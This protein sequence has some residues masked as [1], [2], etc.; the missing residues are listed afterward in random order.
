MDELIEMPM[1][2]LGS[3]LF[4]AMPLSLR[5]FEPRYMAMLDALL[6][7][8]CPEFGVVLIERGQEV[9]GG[10]QRFSHG[11]VA[12]IIEVASDEGH[13]NVLV[14]GRDRIEIVEWLEDSP[15]P[16]AVVRVL[17]LLLWEEVCEPRR[18]QTELLVRRTLQRASRLDEHLWPSTIDLDDNPVNHIWQLAGIAPIGP[19]DQVRLLGA[20]S[21]RDLL[22]SIFVAVTDVAESLDLRSG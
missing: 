21:V 20:R 18:E 17:P 9:G 6:S 3:V 1:F 22:D 11:T 13:V 5:V 19:L 12:R 4:P 16:R 8:E 10:E 14:T 2:P 15:F 7:T